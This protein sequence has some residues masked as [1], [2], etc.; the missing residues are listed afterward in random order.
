MNNVIISGRLARDPELR[1]TQNGKEVANFS[2]AVEDKYKNQ[3]GSRPVNF[4]DCVAWG[5]SAEFA[6]KYLVKG[7]RAMVN[8]RLRQRQWQDQNGNKRNKVEVVAIELEPIDWPG[9]KGSMPG[10]EE[11][12]EDDLPF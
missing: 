7:N 4:I 10:A 1:Y 6:N 3:D 11:V 8:G 12:S 5:K 2:L 9:Q